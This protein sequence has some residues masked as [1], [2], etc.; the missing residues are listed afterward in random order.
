[1]L[2]GEQVVA[3]EGCPSGDARDMKR[4]ARL[5]LALAGA[6]GLTGSARADLYPG[7]GHDSGGGSLDLPFYIRQVAEAVPDGS[8][9]LPLIVYSRDAPFDLLAVRITSGDPFRDPAFRYFNVDGWG[10][11][12]N[13]GDL[14]AASGP[15]TMGF[16]FFGLGFSGGITEPVAF[17]IVAFSGDTLLGSV[18]GRDRA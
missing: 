16:M 18:H 7:P 17:D 13:D 4:H 11:V 2:S 10:E 1:M 12:L 5:L 6:L 3:V 9:T 14:A 8:W 15:G